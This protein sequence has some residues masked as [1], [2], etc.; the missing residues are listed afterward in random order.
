MAKLV[1]KDPN[2]KVPRFGRTKV[3]QIVKP[4]QFRVAKRPIML[5]PAPGIPETREE[6]ILLG[7]VHGKTASALEERF[8]RALD[9]SRLQ[10]IF[11]YPVYG[12]YQIPGEENKIDFMVFDGPVLIPVEPRGGFIHE[13]PSKKELDKRRT[14]ILNEA[15]ARQGIREIIQLDFDE[16]RDLD[17]AREIVR[18]LF[19][20]A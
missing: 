19:I 2:L 20:R 5:E 16:P 6:E 8:A 14:Q 11:Q 7:F 3:P 1:F 12:A 15:L 13:S 18:K 17:S 9:E 4:F 10:F